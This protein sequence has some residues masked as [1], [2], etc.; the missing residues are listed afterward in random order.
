MTFINSRLHGIL[1]YIIGLALIAAPFVLQFSNDS[2]PQSDFATWLPIGLGLVIIGMSLM[3]QYEYSI[4]KVIAFST[5]LVMDMV[6]GLFLALSPW[7]FGFSNYIFLPHLLVG[8][9]MIGVAFFT[10]RMDSVNKTNRIELGTI[11]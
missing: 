3:T 8:L 4:L 5:H 11:R 7:I 2:T 9:A 10:I 1:D 6:G